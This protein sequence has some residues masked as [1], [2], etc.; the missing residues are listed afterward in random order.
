MTRK[1]V[2]LI[3]LASSTLYSSLLAWAAIDL[4]V[5]KWRYLAGLPLAYGI[6]AA[7]TAIAL[8]RAEKPSAVTWASAYLFAALPAIKM[9]LDSGV[10][11]EIAGRLS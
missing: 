8:W 9:L 2:T 7:C 4:L 1:N 3:F 10:V 5:P 11:E 6:G